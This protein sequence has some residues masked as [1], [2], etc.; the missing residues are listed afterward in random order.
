MQ[1]AEITARVLLVEDDILVQ[2]LLS[3]LLRSMGYAVAT[4]GLVSEA[5]TKLQASGFDLV[6]LDMGLPD[7]SGLDV[8]S[9]MGELED[10]PL[11]IVTTADSS[12]STVIE[13]LRKGAFDYLTKPINAELMRQ[14]LQRASNH[15]TF[16]RAA[17]ELTRL[18]AQEQAMQATARAAVHH[19]SQDLTVIM[20]EAQL[21]QEDLSDPAQIAGLQRIITAVT[22]AASK[23]STLRHAR[24]FITSDYTEGDPIL[25]IEAATDSPPVIPP[26]PGY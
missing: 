10:A 24:R 4:T 11:V 12:V 16:R 5:Y 25:D 8:L 3:A 22:R 21:I 7:G 9:G 6:L 1:A 13:A 14:S 15:I 23:L 17:A 2:H 18:Q 26:E 20:G 19:L